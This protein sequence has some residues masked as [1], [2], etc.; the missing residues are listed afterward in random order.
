MISE[1]NDAQFLPTDVIAILVGN[2][3][4]YD[5]SP[6]YSIYLKTVILQLD[7]AFQGA[8]CLHNIYKYY[9]KTK[10]V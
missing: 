4:H 6:A 7:A 8:V 5:R 9:I 10:L 3:S 2:I 1:L